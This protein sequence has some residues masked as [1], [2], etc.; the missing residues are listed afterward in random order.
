MFSEIAKA[1]ILPG[2]LAGDLWC[3][4]FIARALL[5]SSLT[6]TVLLAPATLTVLLTVLGTPLYLLFGLH[7]ATIG[8]LALTPFILAGALKML[9]AFKEPRKQVPEDISA[10]PACWRTPTGLLMGF[11]LFFLIIFLHAIVSLR[12]TSSEL[13]VWYAP[14]LQIF[15]S[16]FFLSLTS[17]ILLL[18]WKKKS[19]LPAVVLAV[20]C[21]TILFIPIIIFPLGYGFDPLIHEA[22]EK[23]IYTTGSLEPKNFYYTGY[24]AVV[25]FLSHLLPAGALTIINRILVLAVA[26]TALPVLAMRAFTSLNFLSPPT[27]RILAFLATSLIIP[28]ISL[29]TPWALSF[30]F[31]SMS[32]FFS[33]SLFQQ[34]RNKIGTWILLASA[35]LAGVAVHPLAGL[36]LC[37]ISAVLGAYAMALRVRKKTPRVIAMGVGGILAILASICIPLAF[38][39]YA[40]LVPTMPLTLKGN[41]SPL[42]ADSLAF[43]SFDGQNRFA[44]VLNTVYFF[45]SN[46]FLLLTA[47]A[48]AGVYLLLKKQPSSKPLAGIVALTANIYGINFLVATYGLRFSFLPLDAQADFP[49]RLR[50]L[51]L[52]ALLPCILIPLGI[53]IE[54][55]WLQSSRTVVRTVS[56][57]GCAAFI[58]GGLYTSYPRNDIF[59]SYHGSTVSASDIRA[60]QSI[61]QDAHGTP[62]IVLSNQ[63]VASAAVREF[64]FAKYY[65]IPGPRG[66]EKIFYYPIPTT[67]PLY[68]YFTQ[69]LTENT[70]TAVESAM[71]LVGVQRAYLVINDYERRLGSA[72]QKARDSANRSWRI[73]NGV[74][75]VFV[76]EKK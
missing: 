45:Y 35:A 48:G 5:A 72:L 37:G 33:I 39:L 26:A 36:P 9:P 16:Y 58:T 71:N 40:H 8:I 6:E 51:S 42:I 50:D 64:G 49:S 66:D 3:A 57:V 2:V 54:R 69:A 4:G 60:A 12:T 68:T 43:F 7:T 34:D 67:S 38:I 21:A 15:I 27:Q 56:L 25:A 14:S 31:A 28:S 74:D 59:S 46:R 41:F 47:L 55:A 53:L 32:L 44:F 75:T 13:G 23:I 29:P 19:S 73:D 22:A 17:I 65:T 30:T 24:Y 76:F 1:I 62:Y 20:L 61:D 63:V 18:S 70:R 11:A 10:A 52:M